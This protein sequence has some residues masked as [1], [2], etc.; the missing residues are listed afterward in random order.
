[1]LPTELAGETGQIGALQPVAGR[2]EIEGDTVWFVPRFA[3]LAGTSYSL[4][5]RRS[6]PTGTDDVEAW[7]ITRP[8]PSVDPTTQVVAVYPT[9]HELPVNQLK[10]YVH[11]SGQ[12]GEGRAASAITVRRADTGALLDGVFLPMEP[13][14]W[15]RGRRRLTVLLD[16]GRIKRGLAPNA[17]AGYP[18]V[19]GVPIVVQIGQAFRDALGLP[20]CKPAERRYHVGPPVRA[21][22]DPAGWS[23]RPPAAGSAEALVI[24]FDRPL[25]HALLE[26][27][28][29]VG[30]AGGAPLA[31]SITIGPGERSWRFV[32][33]AP[34]K[35]GR[36]VVTV[37]ARLEDVAGN[38][39][40]RV[41]DR[42][43]TRIDQSPLPVDALA[44]SFVCAGSPLAPG[45][46]P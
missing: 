17:E 37:D 18:L 8:G 39:V 15:D 12:M 44:I 19:E 6:N 30:D 45:E 46:P 7:A 36:H 41:F 20:L 10:L 34:W 40:A 43:L 24:R 22:V 28:L 3:F 13:E 29:S 2:F 5:V 35:T 9:A 4:L 31:G 33:T 14:L 16:P 26:H 21:R 1:V 27:C 42:D 11:F 23:W 25:D 32:P 38:S